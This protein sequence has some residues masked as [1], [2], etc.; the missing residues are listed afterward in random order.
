MKTKAWPGHCMRGAALIVAAF[1]LVW[2]M[3][4]SRDSAARAQDA[5]RSSAAG[6]PAAA[7][8]FI[9]MAQMH[10]KPDREKDFLKLLAQMT[11]RAKTQDRGNIR[12]ELF[13]VAPAP[14]A[15]PGAAPAP[16]YV[17]LEEWRDQAAAT[18]HGKWAGPIVRTQWREMTDSMQLM[19][20]SRVPAH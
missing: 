20:L 10:V 8:A 17:F 19:R 6:A 18:A 11:H 15:A 13:A 9:L 4:S 14:N 12:Y 7:G 2:G 3:G 1:T 16:N 5:P